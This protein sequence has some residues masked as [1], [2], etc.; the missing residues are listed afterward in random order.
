VGDNSDQ[1]WDP[2]G[3]CFVLFCFCDKVSVSPCQ[4]QT[5]APPASASQV[6][7]LQACT[8]NMPSQFWDLTVK[9]FQVSEPQFPYSETGT[10]IPAFKV[11]LR[12]RWSNECLEREG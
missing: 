7:W 9:L 12:I 10:T 6:L 2:S 8:I 3:F 1:F 5:Q 4:P 11:A